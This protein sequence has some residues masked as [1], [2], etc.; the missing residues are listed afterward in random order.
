MPPTAALSCAAPPARISRQVLRKWTS[1]LFLVSVLTAAHGVAQAIDF[2]GLVLG[3]PA[4]A[5]Q[6]E[7]RL[8]SSCVS[9]T[10]RPCDA[11][12]VTIHER[13]KVNCGDGDRGMTVCNGIT[14]VAG[15]P[16][17]I[18]VV[19][20]VDGL[21]RRIYLSNFDPGDFEAVS[22]E[23]RRKFG[24]PKSQRNSAVQNAFGAQYQQTE[25]VW[26]DSRGRR[27]EFSRYAGSV[28]RSSL[29]FS[30]AQ[31]RERVKEV[32]KGAKGDL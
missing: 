19:I 31:D 16:A 5:S 29:Y 21:L 2:K 26:T 27:I 23:L 20:G 12:E 1:Q 24:P 30:T 13:R 18:N 4:S 25:Q 7:E 14:T 8:N 28:D 32:R 10:N 6:V 11:L 3:E 15:S 22:E 17:E 9:G